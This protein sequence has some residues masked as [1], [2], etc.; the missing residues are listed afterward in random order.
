MEPLVFKI[1]TQADDS[2]VRNYEKSLGGLDVSSKKAAGALKNFSRDLLNAK[3]GADVA[4]AGAESLSRVLEKSLAGVVVIG[5]IKIVTDQI[6]KMSEILRT[7]GESSKATI[8][9]LQRMGD[10]KGIDDAVKQVGTVNQTLDITIQKLGSIQEGN[11]FTKLTA[12]VTGTTKE[13]KEQQTT[14]ERLRDSLI[15]LGFA[16]ERYKAEAMSALNDEQKKYEEIQQTLKKRLEIANQIISA[17]LKASAIQDAN[18]L[19][20]IETQN[21]TNKLM[22]EQ[23]KKEN[24]LNEKR[25][26]AIEDQIKKEKE[27]GEAQQKRFNDLYNAEIKAQDAI[28]KRIEANAEAEAKKASLTEDVTKAKEEEQKAIGGAAPAIARSGTGGSGTKGRETSFEKG[29]RESATREFQKGAKEEADALK[30]RIANEINRENAAKGES[31][32][33]G[34]ESSEVQN[35]LRTISD[36]YNKSLGQA[37]IGTDGASKAVTKSTQA[38]SD[39]YKAQTKASFNTETFSTNLSDLNTGFDDA[40]KSADNFSSGMT[41]NSGNMIEDFLD[42]GKSSSDLAGEF[43]KASEA[44]DDFTKKTSASGERGG[45]GGAAGGK[46]GEKGLGDIWKLLDDNLKEMRTYAFVK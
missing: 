31:R 38:L 37:S 23:A 26:K 39:Y 25:Q 34:A 6:N 36:A 35:R 14:F 4:A 12:S 3:S 21:L 27:L 20:G 9:Q 30:Q 19:A 45:G 40:M 44:V 28:Q 13:L 24:E 41:E 32:R 42:T 5:G 29:L 11:W 2:G 7:V 10:I 18:A 16:E 46:R 33:V 22:E 1:E 15:A 8:T 43:D 17:D